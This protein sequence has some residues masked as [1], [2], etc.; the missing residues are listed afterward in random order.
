MKLAANLKFITIAIFTVG[1]VSF[2]AYADST[3]IARFEPEITVNWTGECVGGYVHGVGLMR[4][5]NS[6]GISRETFGRMNN[7][8]FTG[9]QLYTSD[10]AASNIYTYVRYSNTTIAP[11]VV[12]DAKKAYLPFS[13][14]IWY[15]SKAE[16]V[17]NE[18]PVISY[19]KALS[20]I[21][22]YIAQRNE[23]SVDFEV[24]KGLKT[25]TAANSCWFAW[26]L[27]SARCAA[28]KPC[29]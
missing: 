10:T 2:N 12:I 28:Q 18:Q 8:R 21:K 16:P 26:R 6:S 15:D 19:E 4:F 20:D 17:N 13:Q 27:S 24:F 3:C 23:P 25:S 1:L 22:A 7:G 29:H 5:I 14:R 11:A 9:L